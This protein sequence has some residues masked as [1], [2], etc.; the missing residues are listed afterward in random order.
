MRR[1]D[2]E[3]AGSSGSGGRG[4]RLPR[5]AASAKSLLLGCCAAASPAAAAALLL[6]PGRNASAAPPFTP[7]GLLLAPEALGPLVSK[8][9]WL[10][11]SS[12]S[13]STLVASILRRLCMA[14]RNCTK[15]QREEDA[16][17]MVQ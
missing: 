17:A 11:T 1:K 2:S 10:S 16:E 14:V 3:P 15:G 9:V 13:S 4:G 5:S 12:T 6:P 8:V 7:P